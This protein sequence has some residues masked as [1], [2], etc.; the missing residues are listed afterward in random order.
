MNIFFYVNRFLLC[1]QFFCTGFGSLL[2]G[3]IDFFYNVFVE[4]IFLE[5]EQIFFIKIKNKNR[6]LMFQIK[7]TKP[8]KP[9]RSNRIAIGRKTDPN[10]YALVLIIAEPIPISSVTNWKKKRANQTA[11]TLTFC[12]ILAPLHPVLIR[13]IIVNFSY[14]KC[15]LF[16]KKKKINTSLFKCMD[17]KIFVFV[18]IL[19]C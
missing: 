3:W 13:T 14:P 17:I 10:Q 19:S 5:V 8:I 16:K 9:S 11:Y 7:S 4:H 2:F 6:L 12:S 15:L 18:M 1:E